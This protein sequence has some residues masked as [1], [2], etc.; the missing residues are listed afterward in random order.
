[1]NARVLTSALL[2]AALLGIARPGLAE[3]VRIKLA[4]L[5]PKGSTLHKHLMEMR[6][7]WRRVAPDAVDLVLFTD[8]CMGGE[9]DVVRKMRSG[10]LQAAAMTAVGLS[11]IDPSM[12]ALQFMPLAFRSWVEVDYVRD[13]MKAQMEEK[14]LDKGYVVLFWADAGW[15]RYFS[16]QPFSNPADLKKLKI[17]VWA[18]STEHIDTMKAMGFKP[19]PLETGDI[20]PG[21]K[22]GMIDV[23]PTTPVYA[24]A[25]QF[26][27]LAPYMLELNWTPIAGGAVV[28]AKT[29]NRLP[30]AVRTRLR[31]AAEQT[32][33][34]LRRKLR[35][36]SEEA[37]EAMKARGLKVQAL[38]PAIEA[39]WQ[40]IAQAVQPV[41]RGTIVPADTFDQVQRLLAEYRAGKR[42][43]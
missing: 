21:L 11:E 17:F 39:E 5:A 31:Q 42:V 4:T 19:V 24:N 30:E 43:P 12:G 1:M 28:S 15:V 18:G 13:R 36:E 8:G 16:R 37:V 41:V 22:T 6:D 23:V 25:L 14:L 40:K 27:N 35:R 34:K 2:W 33:E 3:P 26:Y 10:Q 7:E 38:T 9:R 32:G 29:W 20:L